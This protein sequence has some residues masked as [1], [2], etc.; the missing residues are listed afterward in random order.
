MKKI[1]TTLLSFGMITGAFAQWSKTS[2]KGENLRQNGSTSFYSVDVN[3]IRAQLATAQPT[4]K[5]SK[6]V[7]INVPT[8]EGKIEKFAVYSLPVV[9]QSL[10][11]KY[12]LGSYVGTG[13]DDPEKYIRFSVA[14]NDFQSMIIKNGVSEFIE[15]QNKDK[16]VYAVHPKTNKTSGENGPWLC[17]STES[18]L[19]KKEIDKLTN[20]STFANNSKDF[21]KASDRKYRTMRLA[22]SVNGEYTAYHGGTVAGALTAI[23]A[24]LTRCNGVFEN[25]FGL[26]L[27]LQDFPS[28]IYTDATTDPYSNTLNA[29]NQQLQTTLT[30]NVGNAN[31]DIGHMFGASGGGGNAGCIGCVCVNPTT[32][33]P[34][35]KGAGITSPAD[36][37]P[38]GDNF[39]IDYVAHEMGHQ[40]GGNHTFSMGIE[41]TGQNVEPGTGSTIMGYAGIGAALGYPGSDVQ[42]HSDAYFHINSII[43][44]QTNLIAKTCDVE[45]PV[46]N[47]PPIVAAMPNY[48]IPKGTPFV[49][50]ASATDPENNPITYT[51]EQTDNA[52]SGSSTVNANSTSGPLFRSWTGSADSVRYF[53]RLSTVLGGAVSSVADFES[54]S[55]VA[56]TTNFKVT[57][58][59]NNPD[60]IQQQT[61]YGTQ[62]ITVGSAGPF[63]VISTKV[64]N[65]AVGA[66]T[67]DIAGTNVAPYSVSNVKIDYTTDNGTSW[68]VLAA[69]TPNDGS[70]NFDFAAFATDSEITIRVSAIDNVFYAV[71]K[72]TVSEM[73]NCDGTAPAGLATS[74]ITQTGARVDWDAIADATYILRYKKATDTNWTE[75][76]NLTT[77]AY[78]I[79]GLTLN[80]AYNLSVA[81]ICTGTV[82]T[83]A[84]AD[85]TTAGINYCTAGATS[86]SFEKISNVTF[87]TINNSSTSTSGYE[88]FTTVIGNISKGQAYPFSATFSGTSYT[89]DQVLVWIDFNQDGDFDDAGELVLTTAKKVAPWTGNITIPATAATGKTRM[90]VRLHDSSLGGNTTSCGTS[91]YGQVEDYSV[92]IGVLAVNDVKKNNI[93]VYPNP[94][95]DVI[96]ISNVSSKTR[97]EIYNV[98]GQLVNQGT[99]DGKVNVSKLTKGVYILTVE[100]NG[101]K[102]QT[103]FIKN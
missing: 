69:S 36:G 34:L 101:E 91:T 21:S 14:P 27:I 3:A 44:V 48:T 9:V 49:L 103:K 98:G 22:M 35:G 71:G 46:V 94:A 40:L 24:T 87:A 50:T 41:G 47:Q 80:T 102:S 57:V 73:A 4:G 29:W 68:T 51:W 90:R 25:D 31:Y 19:S 20:G 99:T 97:F 56:R 30:T 38:Q 76:N 11:D 79:A 92:N 84:T 18:L 81:A 64:Y 23:N 15:P 52:S 8:L 5:N 39:D 62:V 89:D 32:G 33:T 83:Y 95:T 77:N 65:N 58:R 10:A 17:D 74:A 59:D 82:G 60:K 61:Q 53:P 100:S 1:F 54:V 96:N 75:V 42:Q 85:F 2:M 12:Q 16:S 88:D 67:W 45:T 70:E 72:V 93:Q 78:T 66:F 28:V 37:I 13:I 55:N 86:T 6:P 26:H 63:K 43:Q 7:I